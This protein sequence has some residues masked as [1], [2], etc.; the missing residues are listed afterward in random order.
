MPAN[1]RFLDDL[2][3]SSD[4]RAKLRSLGAESPFALL[5]TIMAS[6]KAFADFFGEPAT[7][8]L[9]AQLNSRLTSDQKAALETPVPQFS[10]GAVIDQPAR[11]QPPPMDL[12]RREA[13]LQ[14]IERLRSDK[15][16]QRRHQ[17]EIEH[18]EREIASFYNS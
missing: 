15:D 4:Q 7:K 13:L 18:L 11:Y 5:G 10:M 17:S 6:G 9:I 3:L 8:S 2:P 16:G 14:K 1:P 12:D